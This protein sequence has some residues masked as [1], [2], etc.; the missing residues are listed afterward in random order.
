MVTTCLRRVL[1]S[2]PPGTAEG[3][4]ESDCV[5]DE[6]YHAC[7]EAGCESQLEAHAVTRAGQT[8]HD[9]FRGCEKYCENDRAVGG[10]ANQ[11]HSFQRGQ[12]T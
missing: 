12:G 8:N 1:C 2:V 6:R 9:G 11:A 3:N 10:F 4:V 5:V 7:P